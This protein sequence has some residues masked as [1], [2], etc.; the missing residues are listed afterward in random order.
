MEEAS[1]AGSLLTAVAGNYDVAKKEL[2]SEAQLLVDNALGEIPGGAYRDHHAHIIGVGAGGTG[3]YLNKK[4]FQWWHPFMQLKYEVLANVSGMTDKNKADQQYVERLAALAHKFPSPGKIYILAMA[5]HFSKKG[6]AKKSKTQLHVPNN[7]ILQVA[8]QHKDLF[9]PVGSVHPYQPGALEEL[10]RCA[11]SGCRIIKWLPNEMGM[12]PSSQL[13]IP[14]YRKMQQHKMILLAHT[15]KEEALH[16]TGYQIYGNPLLLRPALD[17]GV[18]VIMAH[19]AGLGVNLDLDNKNKP[20]KTFNLFL[21]LMEKEEYKGLLFGDIA[22]MLQINRSGAALKHLL[23]RTDL[24]PRLLQGSD[25][26]LPAINFNIS[27]AIL[28]QRGYIS[29]DER[30]PLKEIYKYNPLLFDAV[31]K[32]TLQHPEYKTRFPVSVFMKNPLIEPE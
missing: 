1:K 30:K 6:Q 19:C 27:L 3:C 20:I 31:C 7:Y 21:R 10:D 29:K 11:E 32:R 16:T 18:K 28:Q 12:D 15:G 22:A 5:E 25:Y 4:M 2:S 9:V 17:T 8:R 23:M 14:F 26:P 24:H 13:C